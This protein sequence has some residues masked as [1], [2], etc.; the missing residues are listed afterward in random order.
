[1]KIFRIQLMIAVLFL[2][3]FSIQ[4]QDFKDGKYAKEKAVEGYSLDHSYDVK[5]IS[6]Y[7]GKQTH[8]KNIILLIGDGMGSSHVFAGI[9]A[10]KGNTYFQQ[11]LNIGYSKTQSANKYTTDSAAGG[12]AISAGV[13][14][15]NGSI[16][17]DAEGKA[18]KTIL[19]I[20]EENGKSTGLV[21][22]SSITH[23]TPASFIAHQASR[24]MYD[25]IAEDFLKT[26]IEV[27]IGGGMMN[28]SKRKDGKDLISEL[29]KKGYKIA[30]NLKD[31]MDF[32]GDK[33]AAL[34]YDKHPE[35][36]DKRGEMLVPATDKSIEILNKNKKGFFLMV[37]GSQI[38]W[39]AHGNNTEQLIGELAD[40]DRA[41]G[42][43]LKFAEKDGNTLVIVTADHETG[44]FAVKN[45]DNNGSVKGE[46]TS[47]G[48]T[49][50]MVPVFAY[51]PGA[52]DFRGIY[53]NTEL[54]YKM[55]EAFGFKK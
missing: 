50:T 8:A 38:D 19:E 10:N 23:A 49:A 3:A 22:T 13:K 7:K 53:E 40:F 46:F 55:V 45:G 43:A 4:A 6:E 5:K 41:I 12:T 25:E 2:G 36:I 16:G 21:A 26:D 29:E 39:A 24:K 33:L 52:E 20:A 27:F 37:E 14:T 11:F 18:V 30:D 44:G 48:H 54:F 51:G 31:A 34:I 17:V 35:G 28:F 32:K 1:M 47:K 9:T 42:E 15:N